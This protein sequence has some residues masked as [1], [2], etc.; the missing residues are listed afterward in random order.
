MATPALDQPQQIEVAQSDMDWSAMEAAVSTAPVPEAPQEPEN[1]RPDIVVNELPVQPAPTQTPAPAPQPEPETAPAA[2]APQPEPEDMLKRARLD[3]LPPL[4]QLT[5][6][7]MVRNP[8]LSPEAAAAMARHQLGEPAP[9]PAAT[10]TTQQEEQTPHNDEP[11]DDLGAQLAEVE[12]QLE[13]YAEEGG[14]GSIYDRNV[15]D[16]NRQRAQ[17]LADIA[18]QRAL[19]QRDASHEAEASASDYERAN[20]DAIAAVEAEFGQYLSDENSPLAQAVTAEIAAMEA[21]HHAVVNGDTSALRDPDV[22]V[23]YA[24]YQHPR[25]AERLTRAQARELG[26]TP[27]PAGAPAAGPQTKPPVGQAPTPTTTTTPANQPQMAPVSGSAGVA[28]VEVAPANPQDAWKE[29][30]NQATDFAS[31]ESALSG[32]QPGDSTGRV[33]FVA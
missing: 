18:V 23:R 17:L 3:R 12:R 31:M 13:E 6:T 5:A 25:Y 29:S 19:E 10:Q 14:T 16:L 32:N 9:A 26:I 30:L 27:Q 8:D 28:R 2:P 21:V 33:R 20:E 22:A 15:N 11:Q 7:I 1:I 24:E 4:Q